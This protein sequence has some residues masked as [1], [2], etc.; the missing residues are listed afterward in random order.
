MSWLS[1]QISLIDNEE[2]L[3]RIILQYLKNKDFL[4]SSLKDSISRTN[5]LSWC[6]HQ[7]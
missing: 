4:L 1:L 3:V 6:N 2:K 5:G 7:H